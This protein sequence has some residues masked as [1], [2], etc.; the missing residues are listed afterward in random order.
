[1][2]VLEVREGAGSLELGRIPLSH[3]ARSWYLQVDTAGRTY[4]AELGVTDAS[5]RFKIIQASNP[6][7]TPRA[8][9][10]GDTEAVFA[11]FTQGQ[12]P[13]PAQ[14]PPGSGSILSDRLFAVSGGTADAGPDSE[15]ALKEWQQISS[16]DLPRKTNK[17]ADR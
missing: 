6:S 3:G 14:A 11:H 9:A 1:L 7:A 4:R 13:L 15:Q 12:P 16:W 2:R 10:S 5:G 17:P 8:S